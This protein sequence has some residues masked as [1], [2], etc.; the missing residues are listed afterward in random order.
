M[1]RQTWGPTLP[2]AG[3]GCQITEDQL[4]HPAWVVCLLCLTESWGALSQASSDSVGA[5]PRIR[6]CSAAIGLTLASASSA[7]PA[8]PHCELHYPPSPCPTH[9]QRGHQGL[10]PQLPPSCIPTPPR[11]RGQGGLQ[12]GPKVTQ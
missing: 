5:V 4:S 8:A 2:L 3:S 6:P 12:M 1:I 7:F 9:P 10:M 11:H